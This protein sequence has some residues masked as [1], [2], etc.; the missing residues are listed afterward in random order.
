MKNSAYKDT[1]YALRDAF[2]RAN[3]ICVKFVISITPPPPIYLLNFKN[4]YYLILHFSIFYPQTSIL[5]NSIKNAILGF[6]HG[7]A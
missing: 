7:H 2:G 5:K 1:F 3:E 6:S 4:P